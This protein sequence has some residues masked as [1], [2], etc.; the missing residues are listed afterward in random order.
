L[1]ALR[2][3]CLLAVPLSPAALR[4]VTVARVRILRLSWRMRKLRRDSANLEADL[5]AGRGA[6][7]HIS[8]GATT[9]PLRVSRTMTKRSTPTPEEEARAKRIAERLNY[10]PWQARSIAQGMAERRD[11]AAWPLS[12]RAWAFAKRVAYVVAVV[13]VPW[14]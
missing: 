10:G 12:R 9:T 3:I 1:G 8:P 5:A 4:S 7:P 6:E 14:L 13:V 11:R 2:V